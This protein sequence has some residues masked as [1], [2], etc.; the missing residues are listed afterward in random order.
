MTLTENRA[1][2]PFAK[3]YEIDEHGLVF[4]R[5]KQLRLTNRS[6]RWFAQVYA[7]DGKKKIFD[8]EKLAAAIFAPEPPS[9]SLDDIL[10]PLNARIIPEHPRYAVTDYGA[11]YCIDPP[12]RGPNAGQVYAV[13]ESLQNDHR[14]VTLRDS[15]GQ[16][17]F[18]RVSDVVAM[19]WV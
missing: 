7:D 18:I 16:A 5:N 19:V 1:R 15:E 11:I 3:Q 14:Y 6:G 8:T 17:T 4:R 13:R 9:L 2:I 10:G 12:S